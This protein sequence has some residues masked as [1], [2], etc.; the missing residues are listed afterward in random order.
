MS[1]RCAARRLR[2]YRRYGRGEEDTADRVL[3]LED[4]DS[5]EA[6][7]G[8]QGPGLHP[9]EPDCRARGYAVDPGHGEGDSAPGAYRRAVASSNLEPDNSPQARRR[10]GRPTLIAS[11]SAA[12]WA[13]AWARPQPAATRARAPVPVRA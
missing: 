7:E 11:V 5:G 2:S 9:A 3:P 8:R 12:V 10:Q 1:Q 13:R 6:Q 4:R